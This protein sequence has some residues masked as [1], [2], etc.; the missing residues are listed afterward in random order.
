[1]SNPHI[2]HPLKIDDNQLTFD[3][4]IVGGGINGTAIARDAAMRGLS[5]LL[6]EK[7]DFGSGTTSWSTRL[8]HGGLRYLEHR[9]IGL[10]RESLIERQRLL[11]H[12]PH[13]VQPLPL[14][15]PMYEGA[16]RKPLTIRAGLSLYDALSFGKTMP[17]HR[18]FNRRASIRKAP[19]LNRKGLLAS[20]RYFDAQVTYPERLVIE[21]VLS[22]QE[23][24]AVLKSYSRVD[25]IESI[26]AVVTGVHYTDL[27]D[28]TKLSVKSRFIINVAGPWVD[29]VLIDSGLENESPLLGGTRGSHIVVHRGADQ[30]DG[31]AIYYEA[32]SD[33][34]AIFVVP[35][36]GHLLIGTTD[37]R[38]TGDLDDVRPD[39]SEIDYL[40][41]ETNRLLP[42]L[43]LT[44]ADVLF[45]YAG[46]RPLPAT[47][48]GSEA[49]ITRR[50]IVV[51]HAPRHH[52]LY[53]VI[54]GKLTTHRS[55]A[56]HAVDQIMAQLD[57]SS[58][59]SKTADIPLPGAAGVAFESFAAQFRRASPFPAATNDRLLRLYGVRARELVASARDNPELGQ[60]LT[61]ESA[62]IVAEV[63]FAIMQEHAQTLE[64]ILL[65]R[66]MLGYGADMGLPEAAATSEAAQRLGIWSA[67]EVERQLASYRAAIVRFQ[68][69]SG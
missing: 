54:G 50:H 58:I 37:Q 27:R 33:G 57:R 6:L 31:T 63:P 32:Q 30:L 34:R 7:G 18:F 55:L 25:C 21:Q 23:H 22:A 3:L 9:E 11:D 69:P 1:L 38:Y 20:A 68:V 35:W 42:D 19:W 16:R 12:A 5:V 45:A 48:A 39:G 4:V 56:E 53:S 65:R 2:H 60:P 15:L 49:G 66:T 62:A 41:E 29:T 59:R 8:I 28:G 13:L 26:G 64:D 17:R 43:A 47:T 52:G 24:G 36:N 46:I 61:P 40:L 14:L 67:K 51:D 10:V 44:K